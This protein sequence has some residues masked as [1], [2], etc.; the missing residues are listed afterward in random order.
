MR[1]NPFPVL[2]TE[3]LI[4]R[5]MTASDRD[6][7]FAMRSDERM[8]AY[9]D[10]K[11]DSDLAQTEAYLEKMIQGVNEDRWIIWAIE[12]RVSRRAIGSVGI[13]NFNEDGSSAELSYSI[14]PDEQGKGYMKEALTRVISF[15]KDN[16]RLR[17][18]EAYTEVE[19]TPSR[20]LLERLHFVEVG[21][22]DDVSADG[23]RVYHMIVYQLECQKNY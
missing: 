16:L 10:T 18:L 4:L 6:D 3:H 23:T 9:T 1:F 14:A 11:P 20:K 19:N 22:V 12:H 13:W 2:E 8:H 5:K 21:Q 17:L 15:A 7:L